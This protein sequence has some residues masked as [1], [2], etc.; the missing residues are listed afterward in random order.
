MCQTKEGLLYF[1]TAAGLHRYD[2][3]QM[4][5]MIIKGFTNSNYPITNLKQTKD[6]QIYC[7][8]Y[9]FGYFHLEGDTLFPPN[10]ERKSSPFSGKPFITDLHFDEEST[11]W[12]VTTTARGEIYQRN[13]AGITDTIREPNASDS[14]PALVLMKHPATGNLLGTRDFRGMP[15]SKANGLYQSQWSGEGEILQKTA[16][17]WL[18]NPTHF[19]WKEAINNWRV[20][21][22]ETENSVWLGFGKLLVQKDLESGV[23]R[24][25]EIP[26]AIYNLYQLTDG[27]IV[28][29]A[30][31]GLFVFLKE[32]GEPEHLFK[33]TSVS[34]C[35]ED[36]EGA[37]WLSTLEKGVLYLPS[38]AIRKWDHPDLNESTV[39]KLAVN[40]DRLAA[41]THQNDLF[42]WDKGK[43]TPRIVKR[44][45]G[46]L[47]GA[48]V[49]DMVLY[50]DLLLLG[51]NYFSFEENKFS[52]VGN[53]GATRFRIIDD[54]LY[55]AGPSK[56]G[57][58]NEKNE[59]DW[60][61]DLMKTFPDYKFRSF[62]I[63]GMAAT[64]SVLYIGT[65]IGPYAFDR[66]TNEPLPN[67]T[68][69]RFGKRS[70]RD[71]DINSTGKLLMGS[72]NGLF[73]VNQDTSFFSFNNRY[74]VSSFSCDFVVWESDSVFWLGTIK[75][76]NRGVF[77]NGTY[78]IDQVGFPQGLIPEALRDMVY[79]ND[80]IYVATDQGILYFNTKTIK[81]SSTIPDLTITAVEINDSL[82]DIASLATLEPHQRNLRFNFTA[83]SFRPGIE[84]EYAYQLKG[85]HEGWEET[86][87]AF[88]AYYNLPPGEYE[89]RVKARS[90]RGP[91]SEAAV[92]VPFSVSPIF[93]E[94]TSFWIVFA[95][96]IVLLISF[97]VYW[98]F[99]QQDIRRKS[100]WAFSNAQ[101]QALGLQMNPHFLF[102][103]LN[104]IQALAYAR[105]HLLVNTFITRLAGLTRRVLENSNEPL[106]PLLE[107]MTSV[108]EY[109]EMEQVR[110]GDRDIDW[111]IEV[112]E[113]LNPNWKI[114]PMLLQ[115]VVEN[116]IWHGL[117]PKEDDRKLA[118]CYANLPQG[119]S[120]TISDNG[121]GFDAPKSPPENRGSSISL[122]NIRERIQL[123]NQLGYGEATFQVEALSSSGPDKGTKVTFFFT[124][125]TLT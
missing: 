108:K 67:H 25:W 124:Q 104:S 57:I 46:P 51:P 41:V 2:G 76:L 93:Y 54:Q 22:L 21:G 96:G 68:P 34:S 102:N 65:Y 77:R 111:T 30:S 37:L 5:Q 24:Y 109:L 32:T 49:Y 7:Q 103:A 62:D 4:E 107:E 53:G 12:F 90:R 72:G 43:P 39:R 71:L 63:K 28:V 70:I 15:Y 20:L 100:D 79:F 99:R 112:E 56:V 29:C 13:A 122:R 113:G 118:I 6:G 64:D 125:S 27:S 58:L 69:K 88:A 74:N 52:K 14:V 73:Q 75:G 117:L 80:T 106:I 55:C 50:K 89:F 31:M 47:K 59:V 123:Y 18:A 48:K 85:M 1:A 116:A 9:G 84:V 101:L 78:Q 40:K 95:L 8:A 45:E 119:Y 66:K 23:E 92:A 17:G 10:E 61:V 97:L 114:P 19:P 120:V 38:L 110:F 81:I 86:R 115:P 98:F 83:R 60:K 11:A 121:K 82:A 91:W 35:F 87:E 33:E 3:F 94:R 44:E 16:L 26:D 36:R 42:I 105:N